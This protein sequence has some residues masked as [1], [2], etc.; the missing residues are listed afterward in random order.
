LPGRVGLRLQQYD[1]PL[2]GKIEGLLEEWRSYVAAKVFDPDNE[3]PRRWAELFLFLAQVGM[4]DPAALDAIVAF[5]AG[6]DRKT[7]KTLGL[8][9]AEM[10]MVKATPKPHGE[11]KVLQ[12]IR[13]TVAD[14]KNDPRLPALLDLVRKLIDDTVNPAKPAKV[15]L[16]ATLPATAD[17]LFEFLRG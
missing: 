17:R 7:V 12:K 11:G 9:E 5:R 3:T 6:E 8:T 4:S 2:R 13:K 15:V 10:E 1:D 14:L 16:F